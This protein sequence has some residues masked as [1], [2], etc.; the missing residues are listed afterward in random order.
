MG[1][2]LTIWDLA[3]RREAE[4]FWK[5]LPHCLGYPKCDA[6]DLV[7]LRH[8]KE[9]PM[10]A[11]PR[12]REEPSRIEFA[13]MFAKQQREAG[14]TSGRLKGLREA[15]AI[16]GDWSGIDARSIEEAIEVKVAE[17]AEGK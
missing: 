13:V 4:N 12:D 16:V 7:G 17:V 1:K 5:S 6:G 14:E 8:Q 11:E 10:R 2:R 9:C 3:L 15:K